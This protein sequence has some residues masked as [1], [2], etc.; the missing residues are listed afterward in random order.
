MTQKNGAIE[1][2]SFPVNGVKT[3]RLEDL[4]CPGHAKH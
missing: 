4:S 2:V 3:Y 1:N